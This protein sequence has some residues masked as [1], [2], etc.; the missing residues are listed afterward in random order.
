MIELP[1]W[2]HAYLYDST[3]NK[4]VH[5]CMHGNAVPMSLKA[6]LKILRN[7]IGCR[8]IHNPALLGSFDCLT[9]ALLGT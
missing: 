2:L 3:I 1:S 9:S 7:L 5:L 6:T 4:N 8:Q